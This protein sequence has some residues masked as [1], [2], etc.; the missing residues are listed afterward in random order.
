MRFFSVACLL[1]VACSPLWA[2]AA[3]PTS[4]E[5]DIQ[6]FVK[7][8]CGKCHSSDRE[9]GGVDLQRF[10]SQEK[11]LAE[12]PLWE[13]AAARV[14]AQEMPPEGSPRP[15]TAD[16]KKF[17]DWYRKLPKPK[18][19]CE[20]LATDVSQNF[21]RGYVMSR[22]ITRL[23]YNNAVRDLLGIDLQPGRNLPADGAGGE[24]FDT[25]GDTLFT[26]AILTEKYLEAADLAIDPILGDGYTGP[27]TGNTGAGGPGDTRPPATEIPNSEIPAAQLQAARKRLLSGTSGSK[28]SPREAAR[29]TLTKYTRLAFRRPV[30]AAEI[31]R[32]LALYDQVTAR[33][34][35]HAAGLRLAF[36]GILVSPHFLFLAEPEPEAQGITRLAPYPL[37][38]RLSMFLWSSIPDEELLQLAE[39]GEIHD[40]AVLKQQVRR[41]LADP[42]SRALGEN[43]AIQWLNLRALGQS[44]RPD[45][46]QFPEF[47]DALVAAMKEETIRFFASVFQE[48]R[49]LLTLLDSDYTFVNESL[50]KLYGIDGVSGPELQRVSLTDRRRGGLL[51]QASV[52]TS[53]SYPLRTS[54][55]LRGRWVLELL[56]SKVPPPPPDIPTL[57]ETPVEVGGEV[58]TLRQRL[59]KHRSKPECSSCHSRMDPLGFGLENFDP[60]GRWREQ[61]SGQPVDASGKL[62]SGEKFSGPAD[63]KKLLQKRQREFQKSLTRKMLGYA[64]GRSLNKFDQCVVDETLK[65][66]DKDGHRASVLVEHIVLSYPFQHRFIK[67]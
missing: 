18:G 13:A 35:S 40:H 49:S 61:E 29:Q 1:L 14:T 15:S 33:G 27:G 47:D 45:P 11:V 16:R 23:E 5:K 56:G 65:A 6:P 30:T 57:E 17:V 19:D 34:E 25:N 12:L 24:G 54:P 37:A 51:T 46:K 63:L 21:Y 36:K 39:S 55:V 9:S 42:R 28:Q 3:E 4:Y 43:F 48:D 66:L 53:T 26:S 67:N 38:T 64:L 7:K 31:E 22:R 60:M 50:A 32:L 41:M 62:P 58:Q 10:A 44:V 20:N 2:V 8:Y 52:L 59:E